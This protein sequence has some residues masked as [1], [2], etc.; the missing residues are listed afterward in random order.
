MDIK[1]TESFPLERFV[2]LESLE[3]V[4]YKFENE[5]KLEQVKD[6]KK[7]YTLEEFLAEFPKVE[8]VISKSPDDPHLHDVS[9]NVVMKEN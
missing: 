6:I 9:L 4:L 3:E 1:Y 8:N 7:N 5:R 2:N